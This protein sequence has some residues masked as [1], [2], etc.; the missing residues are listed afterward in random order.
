M[1]ADMNRQWRVARYPKQEEVIG[2]EH[3]EWTSEPVPEPEDGQ[4]LVRTI[5][6]A[7]V[8]AQRG[9]L[10]KSHQSFLENIEIGAVMRGRGV[11][12][13]IS[14]KHPDYAEGDIFVGSLG[15]QDYSIQHPRGAE[16]V[17]STKKVKTPISPLSTELSILGQAGATAYFGLLEVGQLKAGENVLI[18][19]AAGGVGSAA[20]QIARIKG[21]GK[22]V[23][24]AGSD[25]KCTW[26]VD[27]LGYDV[28]IN[29]KTENVA[30][31]IEEL[32]PDGIDIF[33]DNVGG[34]ILNDA[35]AN[36]ALHAR[37]VVCGFISTDYSPGPHYG[38]INYQ[39]M[40]YKRARME[41]FIVFDYWDRYDEAE[42]DLLGWYKEGL[43]INAE[44][45]DDGLEHM[46]DSLA[47]LFKGLNTGVKICRVSPDPDIFG[48]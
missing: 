44:D 36:L 10:E 29:Y 30:E 25:T 46:P 27:E 41:G 32:F 37:V 19:A 12:Q 33:F 38:P 9:Y 13:I 35:L 23:G 15:W 47:S 40:V 7:P 18:S 42:Q 21:A 14:S 45:E 3:F 31:R 2:P 4:F 6:L 28:A 24:I 48:G 8:P 20:G 34:D 5:C 11:G 43:L 39:C 22:V 16:F 26:L 1:S 17:F